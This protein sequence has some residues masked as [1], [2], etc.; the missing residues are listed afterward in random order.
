LY[1]R[2]VRAMMLYFCP[3]YFLKKNRYALEFSNGILEINTCFFWH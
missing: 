3:F 2:G 1:V